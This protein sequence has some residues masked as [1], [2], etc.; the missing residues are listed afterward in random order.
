M[1]TLT[2]DQQVLFKDAMVELGHMRENYPFDDYL[3]AF[4]IRMK[5]LEVTFIA[6]RRVNYT[7]HKMV[8]NK[9]VKING[10]G[11]F[12]NW[13]TEDGTPVGIIEDY[14]GQVL[15]LYAGDIKFINE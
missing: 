8:D 15:C 11:F 14:N 13:S 3:K 5:R 4:Q 1:A 9:A 2:F 10:F 12:H 7:I 6:P